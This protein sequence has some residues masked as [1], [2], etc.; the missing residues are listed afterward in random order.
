MVEFV[1]VSLQKAAIAV[2]RELDYVRAST[3]LDI[4]QPELSQ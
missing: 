4:A 3:V 2:A 1:A